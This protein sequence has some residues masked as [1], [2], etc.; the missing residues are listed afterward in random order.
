MVAIVIVL[1]A[2]VFDNLWL[3]TV[4]CW[5]VCFFDGW[6]IILHEG[7]WMCFHHVRLGFG[8]LTHSVLMGLVSM[9]QWRWFVERWFAVLCFW[10]IWSHFVWCLLGA[11]M[12]ASSVFC[13]TGG[14]FFLWS[15]L[16]LRY[17]IRNL[18]HGWFNDSF[19]I[20]ACHECSSLYAAICL[21]W[22]RALMVG[23]CGPCLLLFIAS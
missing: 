8:L 20:D 6:R 11:S 15:L 23:F 3:F 21:C 16:G 13:A 2:Q 10:M 1:I 19:V 18:D 12:S 9:F 4:P 5:L 14:T 7:M 22:E 17:Y